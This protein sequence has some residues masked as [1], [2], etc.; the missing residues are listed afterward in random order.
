MAVGEDPKTP[1]FDVPR[2]DDI[3]IDG[4]ADDWGEKGFRVEILTSVD[5][6]TLPPANFDPAFRLAW[7]HE[8]L[9]V[10][11]SVRDDVSTENSDENTLFL[12]DSIEIVVAPQFGG[13][14]HYHLVIAPGFAPGSAGVRTKAF[15]WRKKE[16]KEPL[17]YEAMARRDGEGGTV[18][19]L[20]PWTNLGI[21]P[22]RGVETALQILVNDVDGDG[23]RFQAAWYPSAPPSGRTRAMHRIRLSSRPSRSVQLV[24]HGLYSEWAETKIGLVGVDSLEGNAAAIRE[25][26]TKLSETKLAKVEGRPRAEFTFPMPPAGATRGPLEVRIRGNR[27]A[28]IALPDAEMWRAQRLM[29]MGPVFKPPVFSGARFPSCDFP[30]PLL[31]QRLL[32][33]YSIRADFYD[34]DYNKVETAAQPGRY[35]AVIEIVPEK[36]RVLRRY[37]T[38]FRQPSDFNVFSWW[39]LKPEMT[40]D[41]PRELGIDYGAIASQSASIGRFMQW[42]LQDALADD[43]ESAVVLAGLAETPPNSGHRDAY[44][45]AYAMD[46]QWWVGLKRK[47]GGMDSYY[48]H[49]FVCPYQNEGSAATTLRDGTPAEA[50]MKADVIDAI[51]AVCKAWIDESKEPFAVCVA[52]HGVVFFERAYGE[53]DGKPMTVDTPSWMASI[54]KFLS[55]VLMMTLVDQGLVEL[56]APIDTYLPQLRGIEVETPLTI[57]H[58][59]AHTNGLQLGLQPPRMFTDHWGDE[60]NDLEEVI[61]GYYPHLEVG[62]RHGYNGVGYALAGKIIEQVTGEALPQ[63]FQKHLWGPLGCAHTESTDMSAR[64]F[65]TPRDIATLGQMLLNKG[66]YGDMRFFGEGTYRKLLP[67]KLAE[68]GKHPP[69]IEWGIGAVWMRDP[70]L[71]TNTFAHGAAS[72][73]TFRIDPDNDLVIVMTRNRGGPAWGTYHPQ[74]IQAIVAG[75]E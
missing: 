47:L 55:G 20:L 23:P 38:L 8:G 46:R 71:G 19:V 51:D 75:L 44:S 64:A 14:D 67:V 42:Q 27:F 10:L 32:G 61:A 1:P 18:E 48:P 7:N 66:A 13:D 43:K 59:Y 17:T 60:M 52:R 28:R 24:A 37:A 69:E 4:N 54:T 31:A 9:L 26:R 63:F 53:R 12:K 49:S 35:G 73:A 70:G 45:D 30:N 72:A 33:P 58:L 50:G 16:P 41:L 21:S 65:S 62:T 29:T 22:E 39:F 3:R 34:K 6:R 36:G 56:D 40:V 74:F 68:Y 57:R 5:G 2:V 11:I 25:G 15:D